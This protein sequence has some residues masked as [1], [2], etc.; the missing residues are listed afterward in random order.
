[1]FNIDSTTSYIILAVIVI[2]LLS[3]TPFVY[4][5]WHIAFF[6]RDTDNITGGSKKIKIKNK[7]KK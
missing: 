6:G 1:M 2:G 7:N 3:I 4:S 5:V